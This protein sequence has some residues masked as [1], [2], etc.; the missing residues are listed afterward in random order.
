MKPVILALAAV[1]LSGT[2]LAAQH[3]QH[4]APPRPPEQPPASV[5]VP[6]TPCPPARSAATAGTMDAM[7]MMDSM[8]APMRWMDA[9][10][11]ERLLER[12]RDLGLTPEQETSLLQLGQDSRDEHDSAHAAARE[13]L[14]RLSAV[15]DSSASDVPLAG[16][17]FAGMLAAMG[18]AH[19]IEL[20][21]ALQAKALLTDAQRR[22]V[23]AWRVVSDA[24]AHGDI[25]AGGQHPGAQGSAA[26]CP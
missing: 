18:Q 12:A 20:R 19:G 11:P 15:L 23:N 26:P 6:A 24:A 16:V 7:S 22:Q 17:H 8:M 3:A 14:R 1:A 4:F 9:F 21:V 5:A 13:H 25:T 10:A 2:P